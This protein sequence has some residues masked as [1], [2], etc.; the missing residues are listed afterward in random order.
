MSSRK[1]AVTACDTCGSVIG[2]RPCK[3]C[4]A[5]L[6][7]FCL[8]KANQGEWLGIICLKCVAAGA[9]PP[10][11][12]KPAPADPGREVRD[13]YRAITGEDPGKAQGGGRNGSSDS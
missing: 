13:R 6:C 9:R 5:G 8:E 4:G 2:L 12:P 3:R 11:E 7:G 10:E 1:R